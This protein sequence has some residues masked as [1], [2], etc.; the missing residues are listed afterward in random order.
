MFAGMALTITDTEMTSDLTDARAE[1][2]PHAAADGSGAWVVSTRAAR[3]LDRNQAITA[4][5]IA[6]ER[7]RPEPNEALIAAL[8]S[9]LW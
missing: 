2:R 3:L 8:E 5:T 6:E 9:E 7:A 1:F 4:L